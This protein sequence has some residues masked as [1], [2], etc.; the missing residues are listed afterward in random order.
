M[1][2]VSRFLTKH[3]MKSKD[4][5]TTDIIVSKSTVQKDSLPLVSPSELLAHVQIE[6]EQVSRGRADVL[7]KHLC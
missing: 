3:Q 6:L 5:L 7:V 1:S 4:L 2:V